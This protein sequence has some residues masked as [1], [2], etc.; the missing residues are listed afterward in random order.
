MFYK[1]EDYLIPI[2]RV[3]VVDK[4]NYFVSQQFT[5]DLKIPF[6]S[7]YIWTMALSFCMGTNKST[8]PPPAQFHQLRRLHHTHAIAEVYSLLLQHCSNTSQ[9]SMSIP[10]TFWR[11]YILC[12]I[13]SCLTCLQHLPDYLRIVSKIIAFQ[14][15]SY[16]I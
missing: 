5:R 8:L 14:I 15:N 10:L 1:V 16:K 3:I 6:R 12:L 7:S 2:W 9:A 4:V 11:N 13:C